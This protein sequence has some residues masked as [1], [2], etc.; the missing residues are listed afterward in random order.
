MALKRKITAAEHA[1]LNDA[2]KAEYKADGA[3]FI[4]DTDDAAELKSAKD[5]EV[6]KR[7]DAEKKL[8]EAQAALDDLQDKSSRANGDIAA[9]DKSYKEKQA[10]LETQV[11]KL[12]GDLTNER[13]DRYVT[14][15][16]DRIAK[17]FTVPGLV[18]KEIASRLSVEMVDD[19]P[20][21]RVKDANGKPSAHSITDLE[22]EFVDN[23]DYKSIV[24]A[25]KAGGSA[26][27][28]KPSGGSAPFNPTD[29]PA[30]L[31][32]LSSADMVA[33]LKASEQEA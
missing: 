6:E 31:S 32:K 9:L 15:E 23:P 19:K 13:N 33:H 5:R 1:A 17:R 7:R 2:I 30:D 12:T 24:I 28:L 3:G 27:P 8:Q 29:K 20:I 10:A 11:A 25:S 16:A 22:K 21:I 18:R 14:A 4:L 26:D